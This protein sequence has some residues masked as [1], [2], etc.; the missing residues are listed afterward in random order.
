[1]HGIRSLEAPQG[2]TLRISL[3]A[4]DADFLIAL[5]DGHTKIVAREAVEVSGDLKSGPTIGSGPWI[6]QNTHADGPHIFARNPNYFELSEIGAPFVEKLII[7]VTRY[8]NTSAA[9]IPL[10]LDEANEKGLL[11]RGGYVLLSGFG[12]GL[13]WGTTLLRW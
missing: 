10:A 4:P 5:A 2:D 9:S 6:L 1:M 11:K 7:N 3:V 13:A 8:G 12:A